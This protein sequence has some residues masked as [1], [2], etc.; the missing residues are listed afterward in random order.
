MDDM[1]LAQ[2]IEPKK[3]GGGLS[4]TVSVIVQALLLAVIVRT[5]L[6][7]PFTIPS[8]SMMPMSLSSSVT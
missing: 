4:E 8:G 2:D 1:T 6:F 3:K 7:Q 5:L